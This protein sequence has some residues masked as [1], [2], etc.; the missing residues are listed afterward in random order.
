MR[1]S[2]LDQW[3]DWQISLHPK[4]V[5]LGLERVSLVWSQL[6]S[7]H[8]AFVITVA[9]TNGKG[10]SVA[11]LESILLNAGYRVGCFTSPH[12]VRYNER[13]KINGNEATD[14]AICEAFEA[15]EHCRDNI[16]LTYFEF[17]ALAALHLFEKARV[18]VMILEVGLGG[19][20]DAV[21]IVDANAALITAIG[22]DHQDWLGNDREVIGREKA[23][24]FRKDQL[25]VF[26]GNDM[27]ESVRKASEQFGTKLLVSGEDYQ[28]KSDGQQWSLMSD[29]GSRHALPI[30][31]MRGKHQ[32]ENAAGVIALLLACREQLPVK[33]EALKTGLLQAQVMGRFQV[34]QNQQ[35]LIVD[36][37]HN[38]Q[39]T[40]A[41]AENLA[42]FVI[43]GKLR[44]IVGMLRDKDSLASLE[45]LAPQVEQ[46][47][48]VSTHGDRGLKAE[49]LADNIQLIDPDAECLLFNT[50]SE[51]YNS[52]L[53]YAQENDSILVTGSFHIAGE[54][55]AEF[56]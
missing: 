23:G 46:R 52:V 9:G 30:P 32:L 47:F 11:M 27:P 1:F 21:N 42:K 40:R 39:S 10:S 53:Q 7:H 5:D 18:E 24:I 45:N 56:G 16:S 34:L 43:R 33:A 26:S 48:L 38:P 29:F 8:E 31:A 51:A 55:L 37:A 6:T 44:A 35:V 4:S 49:L 36:V 12:L 3:L 19:R 15:I 54:F 13:I 2:S 20:L 41:L 14:Q 50:V 28:L 22:I 25:A 17:G